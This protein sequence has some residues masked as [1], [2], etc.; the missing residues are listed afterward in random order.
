[1]KKQKKTE[2]S[3]KIKTSTLKTPRTPRTRAAVFQEAKNIFRRC[4]DSNQ[5]VGRHEERAKI[6]EFWT[7]CVDEKC[8]GGALYISGYPGTGKTALVNEVLAKKVK[9]SQC[10]VVKVNCMTAEDPKSIYNMILKELK[11]SQTVDNYKMA[12]EKLEDMIIS[13]NS[14]KVMQV[15]NS[16][17]ITLS[18]AVLDEIDHLYTKDQEVLYKLFEW[19]QLLNSKFV[20]IGIANAMDLIDRILPRLK[21]KSCNEILSS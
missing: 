4:A 14:S 2:V 5:I 8:M 20:L 1:M 21:A 3:V 15:V 6:N 16:I 13:E 7:E 10:K 11:P 9:T 19:P 18:V 12:I 17:P